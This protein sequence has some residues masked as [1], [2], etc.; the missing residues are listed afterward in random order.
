MADNVS[1]TAGSGTLISTDEVTTLN[2][3]TVAAVQVQ[4]MKP[5]FGGPLV[6]TDVSITNPMP[7][8]EPDVV[9][10][11]TV[12]AA[13]IVVAAPSGAGV[14]VSGASTAGSTAFIACPGGDS[15]WN[16]LFTGSFG[17]TTLYFEVS[18]DSTTGSDGQW[19]AVNGRQ[20]GT[21]NTVLS[22]NTTV[23]NSIYRGN[24]SGAKYLR[25]RA[26]G[27]AAISITVVMRISSGVG[28]TFLNAS[29][30]NGLNTIGNVKLTDGTNFGTIKAGVISVVGDN[31]LVVTLHPSSA[32][33]AIQP[34]NKTQIGS[35]A[36]AVGSG[37]NGTGVQRVTIATDNAPIPI[38]HSDVTT[39]GTIT[40]QNLNPNSGVAT[41]GS[42]VALTIPGKAGLSI[43]I[44]GTYTGALTVQGTIDGANWVT[45][46]GVTLLNVATGN[47]SG[48]I[49][50]AAIGIWQ[51]EVAAFAQVRVAAL[52]TTTGSATVSL[53][54]STTTAN[55]AVDAALPPG[56]NIL[57]KTGID[58]TTPGTTNLVV[59]S[60]INGAN[61]TTG[62]TGTKTATFNGATQ[63][64]VGAKGIQ[65]VA[66]VGTVSGTAPTLV[67]K[68]QGS[69]DGGT[70][71]YDISGAATASLTAAGSYGMLIYPGVAV[72]AGSAL[73]GSDVQAN[74]TLPRTWRIVGT[75]GGTTP[76]FAITSVQYNYLIN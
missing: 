26:V 4:R 57:G 2:G 17:G 67:I 29:L 63:T 13:D 75:I 28:A 69:V 59:S 18:L 58:Q 50:S 54:A 56:T 24:T 44:V 65:F 51:T 73:S 11:Q 14:T 53:E 61:L 16:M 19:I 21:I 10:T 27:G 20:T 71:W 72:V 70:T 43:Q 36:I 33:T 76:S 7:V 3:V 60:Q 47:L 55:F 22:N 23:T 48:N 25:V 52:A 5:V 6:A 45:I 12:T 41:A 40:T 35:V 64:N 32:P 39:A 62:D 9:A 49:A 66:I 15:A 46:G 34:V 42:T 31:A 1:I 74:S 68:A 38:L 8:M 37:V 30:P